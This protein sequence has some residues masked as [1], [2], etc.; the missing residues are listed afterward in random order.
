[1]VTVRQY[2]GGMKLYTTKSPF[3]WS[4]LLLRRPGLR[5]LTGHAPYPRCCPRMESRDC[6][7]D[8]TAFVA[9]GSLFDLR[10][11][12]YWPPPRIF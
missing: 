4:R 2:F 7:G 1:M 9:A 8:L 12:W 11:L 5:T 3:I 10:I 6:P